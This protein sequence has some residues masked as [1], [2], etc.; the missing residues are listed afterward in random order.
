[1][2]GRIYIG[3]LKGFGYLGLFSLLFLIVHINSLFFSELIGPRQIKE[4]IKLAVGLGSFFG[5][6]FMFEKEE[7]FLKI[8]VLI[9]IWSSAIYFS[10]FI[11]KSISAGNPFLSANLEVI[12]ST[13]SKN[14]LGWYASVLLPFSFSNFLFGKNKIINFILFVIIGISVIYIASRGAWVA[15]AASIPAIIYYIS[16]ISLFDAVK[17]GIKTLLGFGLV[18]MIVISTLSNYIDLTTITN[19]FMWV[20]NPV[21]TETLTAGSMQPLNTIEERGGR[22][23]TGLNAFYT[24]PIFGLGPKTNPTH[25]DYFTILA[26]TGIFGIISFLYILSFIG[27]KCN[28]LPKMSINKIDWVSLGARGSFIAIVIASI[29][30]D[31][32]TSPHYWLFLALIMTTLHLENNNYKR[33]RNLYESK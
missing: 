8:F 29:V 15:A 3:T 21:E 7:K 33:K 23:K 10:Y 9:I 17:I 4:V 11:Y 25:S 31:T 12:S 22:I 14:S 30:I 1:M 27:F 19:R 13:E 5:F 16:K 18:V 24:K 2:N 28:K 26:E 6:L 32:Y 20:I